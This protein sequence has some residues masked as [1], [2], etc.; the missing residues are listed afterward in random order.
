[1]NSSRGCLVLDY[2]RKFNLEVELE[3]E[4]K[5]QEFARVYNF[6]IPLGTPFEEIFGV[7]EEIKKD[8]ET[9]QAKSLEEKSLQEKEVQVDKED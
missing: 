3:G 1:M 7:L 8:I 9:M 4:K 2:V 6:A 5:L